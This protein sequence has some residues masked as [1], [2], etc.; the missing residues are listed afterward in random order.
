MTVRILG[1]L[2]ALSVVFNVFFLVGQIKESATAESMP[3]RL[4]QV[5]HELGLDGD[6]AG[7]LD[8]LR[9]SFKEQT[10][11][12]S[13]RLRDTREAIAIELD[14]ES[15]DIDRVRELMIQESELIA[16][17]RTRAFEHFGAFVDLLTPEQ[18]RDLGRR[19][20]PKDG[21]HPDNEHP[22]HVLDRFDL[23]QDGTLDDQERASL[24]AHHDELRQIRKQRRAEARKQFDADGNGTLD[25]QERE[26]MRA[27]F[28]ENGFGPKPGEART[29][30]RGRRRPPRRPRS[31]PGP[32]GPPG[33]DNAPPPQGGD[34][35]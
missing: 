7:R 21:H 3:R 11:D 35:I 26:A 10:A 20:R 24:E 19:L 12:L 1:I 18:R 23:D 6:Q 9:D 29:D 4:V 8:E 13:R 33:P 2:L 5:A 17:R 30:D 14:G 25:A 28:V 27:W 16:V 15:P 31:A 34:P 32:H 22:A